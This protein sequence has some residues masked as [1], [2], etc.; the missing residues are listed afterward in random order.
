MLKGQ[1][2]EIF[3]SGFFHESSSPKPLKIILGSFPIS[4]KNCG[5]IH[6]SRCTTGINNTS[7]K[8]ATSIN[9]TGFKFATSIAGVVDIGA[10]GV[11]DTVAPV[12]LTN[13]GENMRLL[14]H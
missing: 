12:S 8:V 10:A 11:N 2:H 6:K 7:G 3:A 14:T 13:N 1:F 4:S 5:N 9:N